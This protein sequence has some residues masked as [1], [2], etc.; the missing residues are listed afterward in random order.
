[1][2]TFLA[3]PWCRGCGRNGGG[4]DAAIVSLADEVIWKTTVDVIPESCRGEELRY[5][6]ILLGKTY[7]Q[8]HNIQEGASKTRF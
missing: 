7:L 2:P 3:A 6:Y 8:R 4:I 1:M 5:I